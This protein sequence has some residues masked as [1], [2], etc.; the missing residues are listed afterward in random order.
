MTK[1]DRYQIVPAWE[2]SFLTLEEASAYT[3]INIGTLKELSNREDC[4]F[5]LW[6]GRRRL[7]KRKRLDEFLEKSYSI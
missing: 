4:E 1:N 6:N 5:V 7:F 2:K 3:N